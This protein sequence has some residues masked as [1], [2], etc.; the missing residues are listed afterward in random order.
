MEKLQL[1]ENIKI[2]IQNLQFDLESDWIKDDKKRESQTKHDL[3]SLKTILG[4]LITLQ[5]F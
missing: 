2:D 1:I 3:D 5:T 4:H